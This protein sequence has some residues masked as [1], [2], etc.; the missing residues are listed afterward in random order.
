MDKMEADLI[1]L[2]K[3]R[4]LR[5]RNSGNLTWTTKEGKVIPIKDMSDSHLENTIN[6]IIR[7]KQQL[8]AYYEGLGGDWQ[9]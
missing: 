1:D 8:Y 4:W 9:G 2:L 3:E 5:N 7:N 6:M